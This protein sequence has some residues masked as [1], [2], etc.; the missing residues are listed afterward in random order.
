[1]AIDQERLSKA[2]VGSQPTSS[3]YHLFYKLTLFRAEI[4]TIDSPR[5]KTKMTMMSAILKPKHQGVASAVFTSIDCEQNRTNS[6]GIVGDVA[7]RTLSV[8][9]QVMLLAPA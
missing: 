4:N 5:R 2:A 3:I 6:C 1:M 8:L 7:C 9:K